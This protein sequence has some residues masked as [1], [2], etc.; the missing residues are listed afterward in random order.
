MTGVDLS[1]P[2]PL[3]FYERA[4]DGQPIAVQ[5]EDGTTAPLAAGTWS[6]PR[7]GD[8][9]VVGRCRGATLDIGCGAGRFIRAL[10]AAG[11][12]ALGVDISAHAVFLSR[13]QGAAAVHQNVFAEAPDLGRWQHVLLMDGNIGISADAAALLRRSR[14]LLHNNGTIIV[15]AAP[16]GTGCQQLLVRLVHGATPSHPFKWL[17]CDARAITAAGADVGLVCTD[18]WSA[19]GRWFIEL[20]TRP[21]A[22]GPAASADVV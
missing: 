11:V 16:P 1:D 8:D 22:P 9:S 21:F 12:P 3:Q 13:Q 18:E 10:H 2:P 15:E 6:K 19:G 20:S 14:D 5:F 17:A 4:L 7:P